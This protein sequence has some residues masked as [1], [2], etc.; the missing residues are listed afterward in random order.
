MAK[1]LFSDR[2]LDDLERNLD[3]W[4]WHALRVSDAE[5]IDQPD[6]TW[7]V[8]YRSADV[9]GCLVS[10]HDIRR[11]IATVR[12]LRATSGIMNRVKRALFS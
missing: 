9:E 6:A 3:E 12:D 4:T 11:L 7:T 1:I 10:D 8:R 2:E 5:Q